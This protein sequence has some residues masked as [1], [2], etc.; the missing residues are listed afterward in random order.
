[1]PAVVVA[2]QATTQNSPFL[3]KQWLEE[4]EDFFMRKSF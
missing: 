1:M 4:E 3:P 2:G